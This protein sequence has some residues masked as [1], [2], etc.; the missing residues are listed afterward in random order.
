[1]CSG[2]RYIVTCSDIFCL[3]LLMINQVMLKK[4]LGACQSK[5]DTAC[6]A[7]KDTACHAKRTSCL[8]YKRDWLYVMQKGTGC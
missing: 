7:K 1:M 6:H 8:S 2:I 4:G 3:S 5:R